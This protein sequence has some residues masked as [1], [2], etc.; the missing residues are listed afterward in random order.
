[1]SGPWEK[2][3][4]GKP[5]ERYQEPAP[6]RAFEGTPEG[7]VTGIKNFGS[8]M[9]TGTEFLSQRDPGI[10]YATG[11]QDAG[12]RGGF[13]FMSGD[14]EKSAFLDKKIGKDLWG[15]DSFGAYFVKP[16]GLAKIG[17]RSEKPV[18]LDEQTLSRFDLADIAGDVPA[19]AGAVG[20]GLMASGIGAIPGMALTALGAA[21]GKGY[22]EAGKNLAGYREQSAGQI[23][24][25]IAI[26][27][28][29]GGAGEAAVRVGKPIGRFLLGPG[30]RFM[31]PE[32]QA[33]MDTALEQGFK[34][35]A[36]QV[37]DASILS[38]WQGQIRAIFGDLN[39]KQNAAAAERHVNELLM[40]SGP[41]GAATDVGDAVAK[42]IINARKKFSED[43]AALYAGVDQ[44]VAGKP[45]VP[46][47]AIKKAIT[48]ISNDLPT[49]A[50][51]VKI[52]PSSEVKTFVE[53]YG[54]LG[55]FQTTKQIQ[56]LR[57]LFREAGQ[58][59]TLVPGLDQKRARDLFKATNQAME[60]AAKNNPQ[61]MS[62]LKNADAFY[63]AGIQKFDLPTISA[64]T[65][66][67]SETG[68][69][70]PEL[71][72]DYI[73]KPNRISRVAQI[74]Q[75]VGQAEWGK[76]QRAHAEDLFGN[77]VKSTNNPLEPR[78]WDG[79]GL[80][81]ALEKYGRETLETVHG[82]AWVD[83]AYKLANSLMLVQKQATTSGLVA[84]NIALHPLKNLGKLGY[85]R[86]LAYIL[87]QPGSLKYLTTGI[88]SPASRAGIEGLARISAIATSLASDETGSARFTVTNPEPPQQ[89]VSPLDIIGG[90]KAGPASPPRPQT[91]LGSMGVRS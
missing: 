19:I 51:G 24:G 69:V 6:T 32:R 11:V 13:S 33:A 83:D 16:E 73:I 26:E 39:E 53:K 58:T 15:K 40:R 54:D 90:K 49:N 17:I 30:S 87:Q 1:M 85:E 76:V 78:A 65:R 57:T 50:Q 18:S 59:N 84:A 10:D 3:G 28:A 47:A 14:I 23:A 12:I 55:E 60:D 2:Y 64:I 38:R 80:R 5:W 46:T 67:A 86:A 72:V 27:G 75:V 8:A 91:G 71:V 7:A 74:K 43:A 45:I 48:D 62:A 61:A 77:A 22:A 68:R 31:T 88:L 56:E 81:D 42:G 4:S 29:T 63:K 9:K 25:D 66:R 82:K 20:G 35:W 89:P 37:T 52:Y 79:K 70:D 41:K 44:L 34:P 21:G 36:G